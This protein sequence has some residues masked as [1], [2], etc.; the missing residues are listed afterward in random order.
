LKTIC[1]PKSE[2]ALKRLNYDQ[3]IE[4][5][6]IEVILSEEVYNALLSTGIFVT[7]NTI[8]GSN[9]DNFEDDSITDERALITVIE[10]GILDITRYHYALE[11][12]VI[13]LKLLFTEALKRRTGVFFYF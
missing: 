5:D 4:G 13:D 9:I 8:T 12:I 3:T 1:V 7:F 10:S 2:D 6:L 11:H